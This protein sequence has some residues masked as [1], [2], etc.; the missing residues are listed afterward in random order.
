MEL[1]LK[2]LRERKGLTQQE[3]A[4]ALGVKVATYRTW[5]Q[6]SVNITLENAL[7]VS[8]VIGCTPND[9]CDWYATHPREETS[10]SPQCGSRLMSAYA[11]LSEEGREIAENVVAGLVATYPQGLNSDELVEETA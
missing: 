4:D 2:Q 9:L 8:S 5:E 1:V 6:G 7:R 11:A 3:V 10:T